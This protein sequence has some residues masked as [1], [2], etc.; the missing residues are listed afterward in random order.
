MFT[1]QS[2][3]VAFELWGAIFCLVAAFS[4]YK[5]KTLYYTRQ[6]RLLMIEI[7][8]AVLLVSDA[9]AWSFRGVESDFGYWMV[10][11]SNFLVFLVS[12]IVLYSYHNWVTVCLFNKNETMPRRVK[13]IRYIAIFGMIMVVI[14]QFN[15]M[16]YYFDA[17]N[18]Y[19]RN[20]F[21]PISIAIPYAGAL[22]DL[23]L[24]I[25]YR[26]RL[27]KAIGIAMV[28]YIL[29][30]A[31]AAIILLFYYGIALINMAIAV[32]AVGMFVANTIENS[33][34]LVQQHEELMDMKIKVMLSQINPHF[35]Y[36]TLTAIQQLC[37]KDPK[38]A[39]ET[40]SEFATY[41][42][43]NLN[44]LTTTDRIPFE[45]E[46][47]H[48]RVYLSIEQ[49]RFDDIRVCFDIREK[50]FMI[51]PLTVQPLVENAVK[52]GI[53][54]KEEGGTITVSSYL[55]GNNIVVCVQD[56]GVGFDVEATQQGPEHIGLSNTRKRVKDIC[57]GDLIISSALNKG[58]T[59][60]IIL[61]R[62]EN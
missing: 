46:L 56:D 58:T 27:P 48:V 4:I 50:E 16:Y 53:T 47:E 34:T 59:A 39:E 5:G 37:V 60:K 36:N 19:H 11:I 44:S 1:V 54:Q 25:Q 29:L 8:A 17:Q 6:K 42:R 62:E 14:S 26:K 31:F 51:P 57:S 20:T 24:I 7:M 12:D 23:S 18:Y 33:K 49:K 35:L 15:H 3:H 10:R 32:S 9:C 43:G 28:S 38:L 13:L 45:K 2:L 30:P 61:P 52:H 21:Y 55:E 22:L 41:L 40:V